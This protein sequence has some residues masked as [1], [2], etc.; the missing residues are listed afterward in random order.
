MYR[1]FAKELLK[2]IYLSSYN[3]LNFYMIIYCEGVDT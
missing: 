2:S 3:K 1:V